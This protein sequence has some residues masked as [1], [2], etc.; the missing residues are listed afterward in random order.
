[1]SHPAGTPYTVMTGLG[2]NGTAGEM[3]S[4]VQAGAWPQILGG[5]GGP[6]AISPGTTS[7]WYVNNQAG[8]SIHACSQQ[9]ACT[10]DA[11]GASPVVTDAD[12]GGDGLTMTAPAPFLV[13]PLDSTQLLIGTC[14]VWR[15][16]ADGSSW[17]ANNAVSPILDGNTTKT[18]CNGEALIRSLRSEERRVGKE[19]RSRRA[20]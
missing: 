12:V 18:S 4:S 15:G 7:T 11:F 10:P 13:D 5:E 20:P 14:R 19:C 2:A 8:V 17:S 16:P 3:G 1:M 9:G 6:V